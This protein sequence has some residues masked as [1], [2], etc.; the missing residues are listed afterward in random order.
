MYWLRW[1]FFFF[2]FFLKFTPN[3]K[4]A[5]FQNLIY[6]TLKLPSQTAQSRYKLCSINGQL[7][8]FKRSYCNDGIC[9]SS[10]I[11]AIFSIAT[12]DHYYCLNRLSKVASSDGIENDCESFF[13][14]LKKKRNKQTTTVWRRKS[15]TT[16]ENRISWAQGEKFNKYL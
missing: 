13:L 4:S 7:V 6:Q 11:K 3:F 14:Y 5:K 12:R 1:F 9:N 2:F 10:I 8:M 15:W 16:A